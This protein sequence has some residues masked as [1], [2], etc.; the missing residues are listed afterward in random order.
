MS[1]ILRIPWTDTWFLANPF[2]DRLMPH[3]LCQSPPSRRRVVIKGL[4]SNLLNRNVRIFDFG[5]TPKTKKMRPLT[6]RR[7]VL[8]EIDLIDEVIVTK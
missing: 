5:L 4:N 6:E 1:A 7:S 2:L 8:S 3:F